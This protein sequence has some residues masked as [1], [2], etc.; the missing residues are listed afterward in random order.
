MMS[1]ASRRTAGLILMLYPA[2]LLGGLGMLMILRDPST[3]AKNPLANDFFPVAYAHAVVLLILAL[4]LLQ[5]VDDALL[6]DRLKRLVRL[7]AP[8]AALLTAAGFVLSII[9][10]RDDTVN[11]FINL[12]YLGTGV[13]VVGLVALGVGLLRN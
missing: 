13:L 9:P 7:A 3:G 6:S 10:L 12:V 1:P 11:G 4:V 5:Y 8:V 2:T